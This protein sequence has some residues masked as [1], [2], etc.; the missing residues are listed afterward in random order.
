MSR[1]ATGTDEHSQPGSAAP[2]GLLQ[3]RR[4]GASR[5]SS[6]VKAP[7]G[8][9]AAISP[10]TVTPSTRNGAAATPGQ[11]LVTALRACVR[12]SPA[13]VLVLVDSLGSV[14]G[15]CESEAPNARGLP[16]LLVVGTPQPYEGRPLKSL[17]LAAPTDADDMRLL[18]D[19]LEAEHTELVDLPLELSGRLLHVTTVAPRTVAFDPAGTASN[20]RR[21]GRR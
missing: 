7:A 13:G 18:T 4:D 3:A 6:R 15:P 8:R 11:R 12:D 1:P 19:W 21:T 14:P 10:L 17:L 5:G 20:P 9:N 2:P 16:A